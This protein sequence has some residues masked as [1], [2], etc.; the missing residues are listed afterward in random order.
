MTARVGYK[1]WLAVPTLP[2]MRVSHL[3][4]ATAAAAAL[5]GCAAS[6][7]GSSA[8]SSAAIARM[9]SSRS[10]GTGESG[11][12]C[13]PTSARREAW[14]EDVAPAGASHRAR[15]RAALGLEALTAP[16]GDEKAQRLATLERVE[17]ARLAI[18]RISAELDCEGERADQ[19]GTYLQEKSSSWVQGFTV[20]SLVAG[21]ATGVA[22]SI[23]MAADAS[24]GSQLAV[25]VSGASVAGAL[26]IG[27]L[28]VHPRLPFAH[29]RNL[30]ADVWNGPR[31]STVYPPVVWAYLSRP[32]F[33]NLGDQPIRAKIA[34]RWRSFAELEADDVKLLFGTG[35]AYD[36]KALHVR[37]SMLNQVKAEVEL[38]NQ[39]LA[40][41]VTPEA[42]PP[43]SVR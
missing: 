32:E 40:D 3:A 18:A 17:E 31:V 21:A 5:L 30:L 43:G 19:V 9:P 16:L 34:A 12:Y 35:G 33:S 7:G 13:E 20:A 37:A 15:I 11:S 4:G 42:P 41:A 14:T 29:A 1:A 10:P 2:S 27:A 26:G 28:A 8:G 38:L 6:S 22:S 23:L 24:R 36:E 39:E 25:G